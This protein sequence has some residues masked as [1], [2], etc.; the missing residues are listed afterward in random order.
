[1][2]KTTL[3]WL[4]LIGATATGQELGLVLS[5]AHVI[6]GTG[7]PWFEADIGIR[8]GRIVAVGDLD[9]R[10]AARRI[11]LEGLTVAPG[12]IDLHS[13]ADGYRGDGLRSED[14]KR[15]AAPNLVSQGV[16]T[17]VVNQDGR[18]PLSI[19]AQKRELEE[20]KF[21]PNAVLMVGHN[22]VRAMAMANNPDEPFADEEI[23]RMQRLATPAEIATM[24]RL[25]VEGM[26][27]GAYGMSAGLEYIPGRWSDTEEV[28]AVVEAL[29][30][31][32]RIFV[33]HER[34][35]GADP[36]GIS[37]ATRC[38]ANRLFSIRSKRPLR[39]RNVPV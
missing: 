4:L 16:T 27:A 38:P 37:R 25:V 17:L 26:E 22:T 13:H 10:A 9:G 14:A 32:G 29:A 2:Q 20:K 30:P 35:S 15:R 11:D 33:E 5:D 7:N 3:L 39:S 18:S 1:M 21:G 31:Y 36:I 19:A 24:R 34:A 23:G 8:N 28:I 12:F 6:D